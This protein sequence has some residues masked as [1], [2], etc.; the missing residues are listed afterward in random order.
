MVST[1]VIGL[2][3]TCNNVSTCVYRKR[4]K[5]P[6]WHCEEFDNYVLP[7]YN[8]ILIMNDDEFLG[9][10]QKETN[11]FKGLCSNCDDRYSCKYPKPESGIW[12]CEEYV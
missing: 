4:Y 10:Q 3:M 6:V 7:K 9:I 2:C 11:Q 1:N 5:K 12:H 8:Q